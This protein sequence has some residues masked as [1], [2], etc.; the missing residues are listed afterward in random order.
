[1]PTSE[2]HSMDFKLGQ[3]IGKLDT[4]E[5]ANNRT[6][7]AL[8]GVI[9]AQ[10]GVKILGT[11]IL[12]D[13]AT[14]LAIVGAV[15]LGGIL[16]FRFRRIKTTEKLTPTGISLCIMLGAITATQALVYFRDLGVVGT[17]VIYVTRIIQNLAIL[18]FGWRML[19]NHHLFNGHPVP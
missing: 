6:T 9:T 13:I 19:S 17:D 4:M 3:I 7:L 5:R 15:M 14:T 16:V 18:H 12:L 11:P 8:I 2:G 1:M 10:I